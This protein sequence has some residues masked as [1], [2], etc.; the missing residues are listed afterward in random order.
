MYFYSNPFDDFKITG[1]PQQDLIFDM[2][3][4]AFQYTDSES[5]N[6][7]MI[8][9]HYYLDENITLRGEGMDKILNEDF[10]DNIVINRTEYD[11]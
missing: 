3:C 8:G 2:Q 4:Q 6:A 11:K 9:V 7:K 5:K 1:L 10:K